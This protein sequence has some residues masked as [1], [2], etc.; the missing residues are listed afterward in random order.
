MHAHGVEVLN[1]ADDDAVVVFI[2]HNFH[3]VLFPPQ[4]RL[5]D[6]Q[7]VVI[8]KLK[9]TGTDFF[10]LLLVV[11]HAAAGAA[12]GVGRANNGRETQFSLNLPG[13]IHGVGDFRFRALQANALHG[14]IE[15]ITVFGHVNRIGV[16]TDHLDTE[17]L[18]H[19]MLFKL[20]G[21]V[22][23]RLTTH[24]RQNGI[25]ALGFDDLLHRLPGNWLDVSSIGHGRVSHDGGGVGVNQ[26]NPV[27]LLAQR[28]TRLGAG[29]VE[30]AG[31]ADHNR[32][33]ANDQNTVDV[34]TLR[35]NGS[36][37]KW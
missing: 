9:T 21:A 31:L 29:V 11:R 34:G 28:F 10:E 18:Q 5:I 24:G 17:L 36:R 19:A 32:A 7:L 14:L 1:R 30:F 8:G 20:E 13:F 2:T 25:R 33:S 16:G 12:H 3:L 4:Q 6:E 27:T 15:Q 35:H 26:N 22:Q 23:R 37:K